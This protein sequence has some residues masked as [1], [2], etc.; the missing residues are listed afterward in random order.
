MKYIITENRLIGLIDKLFLDRYGVPLEMYYDEDEDYTWFLDAEKNQNNSPFHLNAAGTLWI[1]D[2]TL[3]RKIRA[4]MGIDRSETDNLFKEY[5]KNKF[6]V[7]VTSI[8]SE[9]G[10]YKE[11]DDLNYGDPW[12]DN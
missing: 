10:Y 2:Y 9:G 3:Y 5:F 11:N 1:N 7:R 12:L 8:G 4:L 6:G